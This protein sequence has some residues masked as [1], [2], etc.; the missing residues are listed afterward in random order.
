M[1]HRYLNWKNSVCWEA[2]NDQGSP[3]NEEVTPRRPAPAPARTNDELW[4]DHARDLRAE[5]RASRLKADEESQLRLA[6]E[7]ALKAANNDTEAKIEAAK[8]AAKAEADAKATADTAVIQTNAD[9][10]IIRAE[11]RTF[12]IKAGMVDLD[13]L[14]LADLSTVKLEGDD[15]NG[16]EEVIAAL[17]E[18]KPYLFGK[19]GSGTSDPAKPPPKP[20]DD[21]PK[22]ARDMTKEEYAAAKRAASK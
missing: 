15:V 12:A 5:T 11:L 17:K 19:P 20:G 2:P 18:A 6:A 8:V 4:R 14:K 1:L 9:Q 3:G 10:R 7:A 13:G 21:K 22:A 16:A